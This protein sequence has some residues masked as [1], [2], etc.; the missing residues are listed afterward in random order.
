[1]ILGAFGDLN[2]MAVVLSALVAFGIGLGWFA[3]RSLGALWVRH[4]TR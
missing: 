3:P 4:V 1:M 2:W